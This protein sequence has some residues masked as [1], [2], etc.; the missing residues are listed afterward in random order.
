MIAAAIIWAVPSASVAE[1]AMLG[2]MPARGPLAFVDH[3]ALLASARGRT[4]ALGV[5]APNLEMP[6]DALSGGN[7]QKVVLGRVLGEVAAAH[8]RCNPAST[9]DRQRLCQR[10]QG[11]QGRQQPRQVRWSSLH[12]CRASRCSCRCRA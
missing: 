8:R 11:R 6:I 7:Q 5:K 1:N 3:E 9:L 4:E 10:R 12:C 2:A